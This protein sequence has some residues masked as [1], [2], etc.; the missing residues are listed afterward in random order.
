MFLRFLVFCTLCILVPQLSEAASISG[1][2]FSGATNLPIEYPSVYLL[3]AVSKN[4]VSGATTAADGTYSIANLA[5]G[6]YGVCVIDSADEYMDGCYDGL[7]IG[8]DGVRNFTTITLGNDEDLQDID[9]TLQLGSTLSGTLSDS[10]FNVPVANASAY[11]TLYSVQQAQVA[12]IVIDTSANGAFTLR[13]LAPGSYYLEAGISFAYQADSFYPQRLYGGNSCIPQCAFATGTV[14]D[15]PP[16][17]ISGI[18]FPLSPGYF[19]SG[20]VTDS[21]TGLGIPNVTINT[22][23][24]PAWLLFGTSASAVTDING[25]YLIAHAANEQTHIATIDASGYINVTWPNAV[26]PPAH[27]CRNSSFYGGDTLTFSSPDETLS[28]I[29]FVL[30][31]G[32]AV[33]GTVTASD[34][35][36]NPPLSANVAIYS[37]DGANAALLGIVKT[38]ADGTY[39][40]VGVPAGTYH[41][42]AYYD[43][44]EDCQIYDHIDCGTDWSAQLAWGINTFGST[45]IVLTA[46]QN[47]NGI[48]LQ[49]KAPSTEIIFADGFE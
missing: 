9:V 41:V 19:V 17:G 3:D 43:S 31:R 37:D 47:Q 20:T 24:A 4:I 49:L 11:F 23:D 40:T 7:S 34:L 21:Q 18:N 27:G 10:Y 28:D 13:G 36:G 38:A 46:A 8:A 32:A 25:H 5:P 16:S 35:P 30:D 44:G 33:S 2:V 29:D 45:P 1:A 48:N 22:C 42:A 12:A 26:M 14:I 15:V 39:V 6:D